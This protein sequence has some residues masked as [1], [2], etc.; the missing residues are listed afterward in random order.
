[1]KGGVTQSQRPDGRNLGGHQLGSK[2]VFFLY[3]RDTPAIRAVKLGDYGAAVFQLHLVDAVLIRRQ[4]SQAA[5]AAQAHAVQRVEHGVRGQRLK[6]VGHSV[7][8]LLIAG[9]EQQGHAHRNQDHR[10]P[11]LEQFRQ[12][13][14]DEP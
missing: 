3:L 5:I 11:G 12:T 10:P 4:G 8:L 7:F 6:G 13:N 2:V 1:M 9:G 14:V